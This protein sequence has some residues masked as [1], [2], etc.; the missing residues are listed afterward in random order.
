MSTRQLPL[1]R[2]FRLLPDHVDH[3]HLRRELDRNKETLPG[4]KQRAA[5]LAD[6]GKEP[7]S[8]Q[9]M[10]KPRS[11][12]FASNCSARS[13][14]YW[15]MEDEVTVPTFQAAACCGATPWVAAARHLMLNG[16][17]SP[18]LLTGTL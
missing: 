2:L 16:G 9:R 14:G 5:L 6:A 17:V 4:T 10:T 3:D 13:R 15:A 1:D 8:A 7:H 18:R 11:A 12:R